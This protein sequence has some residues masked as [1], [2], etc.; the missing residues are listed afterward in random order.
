MDNE[1]S[2]E[3]ARVRWYLAALRFEHAMLRHAVALRRLKY[4]PNQPRVPAGNADGGQ[5]T[6]QQ[7]SFDSA[8]SSARRTSPGLAAEC[9]SQYRRDTFHCNMVGLRS[10]HAQ[11]SL[12][13]ANCLSGLPIPPLNY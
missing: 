7:S 9:L 6:S 3:L 2:V 5:W 13:Y 1:I 10:C 4:D 12:R 8:Y 11:A